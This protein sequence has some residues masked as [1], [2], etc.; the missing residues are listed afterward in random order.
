M[1]M[2]CNHL[3]HARWTDKIHDEWINAV[4]KQRPDIPSQVLEEMR[5]LIN[6]SVPDCLISDYEDL[7]EKVTL[8]DEND[9]HVLAA[10]I[11][12]RCNFIVTRN[13]RDFPLKATRQY[14]VRALAP[15]EF[16]KLFSPEDTLKSAEKVLEKLLHVSRDRYIQ[17]I[18]KNKLKAIAEE[19]KAI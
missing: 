5:Y 9:R 12:G 18:R 1:E 10:A 16:I 19:M 6:S 3:F 13:I 15:H 17:S 14:D 2:S 4:K 8:P 11:T 7:I